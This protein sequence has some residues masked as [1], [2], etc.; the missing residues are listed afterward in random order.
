MSEHHAT[1]TWARNGADFGYKEYSR[2]HLWT[3]PRSGQTVKAAAAPA[4]LGAED[5]VDPE[6]AY[7][8][9]LSS[10]HLL[11]FLAI[12]SRSGLVVDRYVDHPVGFLEKGDHGKPWLSRIELRPEITFSGEKQPSPEDLASLH[13]KAHHEC[14][15]ANSVRT[16]VTIL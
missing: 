13:D 7:V 2:T 6:E 4:F 5:C 3:F 15:L 8:A 14:F 1:L 16:E 10:C 11:T 12:A 9:A